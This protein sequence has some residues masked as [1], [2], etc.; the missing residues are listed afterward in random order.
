MLKEGMYFRRGKEQVAILKKI[1]TSY[2]QWVWL[3]ESSEE[4]D[5]VIPH[6]HLFFVKEEDLFGFT[7][8]DYESW[9][10]RKEKNE[11]K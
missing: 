3:A 10:V 2:S 6:P 9:R 11:K 1:F 8:I 5:E 7:E 4:R